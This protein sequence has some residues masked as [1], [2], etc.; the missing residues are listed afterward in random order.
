M[1][2]D[3]LSAFV[4]FGAWDSRGWVEAVPEGTVDDSA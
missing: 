2:C 1:V 4:R 3:R